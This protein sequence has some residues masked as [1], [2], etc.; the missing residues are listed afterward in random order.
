[1][2][3]IVIKDLPR[4]KLVT[5]K[6]FT[7][8]KNFSTI[9]K[10]KKFINIP[11]EKRRTKKWRKKVI[12]EIIKILMKNCFLSES[13]KYVPAEKRRTKKLIK[14]KGISNI[15]HWQRKFEITTH[16]LEHETTSN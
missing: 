11:A 5:K 1:M 10:S 7:E 14:L 3:R 6:G 15:E 4:S 13:K 9:P 2:F 12:S 8:K 16:R